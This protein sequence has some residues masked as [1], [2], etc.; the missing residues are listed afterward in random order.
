M[1][2]SNQDWKLIAKNS[3]EESRVFKK[4]IAE[5]EAKILNLQ[6]QNIQSTNMW[7]KKEN[8]ETPNGHNI[9][10]LTGTVSTGDLPSDPKRKWDKKSRLRDQTTNIKQTSNLDD[11]LNIFRNIAG[12]QLKTKKYVKLQ[13]PKTFEDAI[14]MAAR[15]EEVLG[16][17]N[18]KVMMSA[19]TP[20]RDKG[21]V[22]RNCK[23][24][25]YIAKEFRSKKNGTKSNE[26]KTQTGNNKQH[27]SNYYNRHATG[28]SRNGKKYQKKSYMVESF[29]G[30]NK[31]NRIN[32]QYGNDLNILAEKEELYKF[33]C[34]SLTRVTFNNILIECSTDMQETSNKDQLNLNYGPNKD[35]KYFQNTPKKYIPDDSSTKNYKEIKCI[36]LKNI[37]K[38]EDLNI[39]ENIDIVSTEKLDSNVTNNVGFLERTESVNELMLNYNNN[40]MH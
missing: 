27:V 23:K 22:C 12:L 29:R 19:K 14:D 33:E 28:N 38:E 37:Y 25:G 35:T 20:N 15:S 7:S 10:E 31:I 2:P 36:E 17:N 9:T 30:S 34:I 18:Q 40:I 24:V 11:Y 21:L 32:D 13:N 5:L 1:D 3:I 4:Y 26:N 6:V 39:K 8:M 16:Y